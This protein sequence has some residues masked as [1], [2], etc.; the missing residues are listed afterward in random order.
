M[1][2]LA[3][4]FLAIFWDH[5]VYIGGSLHSLPL[6]I[7]FGIL[8]LVD[9]TSSVTFLPF[10]V[11]FQPMFITTY[12]IGEGMSGLIPSILVLAQGASNGVC[13]NYTAIN[14]TIN[15]TYIV[16]YTEYQ[17]PRF[18]VSVFFAMI[19]VLMGMC[20]LAFYLLN[21][22]KIAKKFY[23]STVSVSESYV[24][25]NNFIYI[26]SEEVYVKRYHLRLT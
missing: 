15:E 20:G 5:T 24:K 25:A 8:C 16:P 23:V 19:C 13:S 14:S 1:G 3:C 9:T 12:Y 21:N 22:L 2:T 7:L 4:L 17:D 10:M 6:L 18:S 26:D 11:G